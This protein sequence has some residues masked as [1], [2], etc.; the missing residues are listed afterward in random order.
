MEKIA[1][2]RAVWLPHEILTKSS[3]PPPIA[4]AGEAVSPIDREDPPP[5][6][7]GIGNEEGEKMNGNSCRILL[8]SN[9]PDLLSSAAWTLRN[10]RRGYD[11]ARAYSA[12]HAIHQLTHSRIDL[13]VA[14]LAH[15]RVDVTAL[16]ERLQYDPRVP[17]VPV[18]GVK[19]DQWNQA[20]Y[21]PGCDAV[22]TMPLI[23]E[24]LLATVTRCLG[25]GAAA[26]AVG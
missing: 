21:D 16:I 4:A 23:P 2:R 12:A 25:A 9:D 14:D 7:S 22:L 19:S 10:A 18:I 13:V 15:G 6:K 5:A 3:A 26:R 11:V 24:A 20:E 17:L 8:V 1:A